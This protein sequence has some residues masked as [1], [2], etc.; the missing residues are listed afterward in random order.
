MAYNVQASSADIQ[1]SVYAFPGDE[2][3][4]PVTYQRVV[5]SGYISTIATLYGAAKRYGI[6]PDPQTFERWKRLG[7]A[8]GQIDTFL[9]NSSDPDNNH[10]L[11]QL[12]LTNALNS[13]EVPTVPAQA[14][15]RLQPAITL[16]YNGVTELSPSRQQELSRAAQAIGAISLRK[17]DCTRASDYIDILREEARHTSTLICGMASEEVSNQPHFNLL[18]DWCQNA[19]TFGTIADSAR[20]LWQDFVHGRVGV[21]PT[22]ANSVRLGVRALPFAQAMSR[23]RLNRQATLTALRARVRFSILP[24]RLALKR[25]GP[26]A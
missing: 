26:P 17:A 13:A 9:D 23:P 15:P 24:T 6:D 14:D 3:I 25:Y 20:D 7:A 8:A 12:G 16:L 2:H 10:R 21:E 18:S 4:D 22:F 5:F 11:Y 1:H 19:I